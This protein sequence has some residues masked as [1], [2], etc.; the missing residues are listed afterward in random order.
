MCL[1]RILGAAGFLLALLVLKALKAGA[2]LAPTEYLMAVRLDVETVS[3][4]N[5]ILQPLDIRTDELQNRAALDANHVIVVGVTKFVLEA[6][7]AVS[8]LDRIGEL[9]IAEHFQ[10]SIDCSA[11]DPRVFAMDHPVEVIH[12][13][14]TAGLQEVLQNG[15]ALLRMFEAILREVFVE[16]V[17]LLASLF[18]GS[19]RTSLTQRRRDGLR[20]DA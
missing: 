20:G 17:E 8:E 2:L 18:T 6:S 15:L 16:D 10:R 14:M 1:S 3:V 9:R 4:G 13:H 5:F 12:G 7:Q 19:H 11:S